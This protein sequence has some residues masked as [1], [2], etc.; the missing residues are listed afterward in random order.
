MTDDSRSYNILHYG[1]KKC[2]RIEISVME[3]EVQSLVLDLDC[4]FIV[5]DLAE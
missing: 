5:K 4:A 3:A 1:S 2:R